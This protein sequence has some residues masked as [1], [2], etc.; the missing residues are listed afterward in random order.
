MAPQRTEDGR[1]HREDEGGD[2]KG[3]QAYPE[4][5]VRIVEA[6]IVRQ[7][8]DEYRNHGKIGHSVEEL[9]DV[10]KPEILGYGFQDLEFRKIFEDGVCGLIHGEMETV[11]KS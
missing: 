11:R 4:G 2:E 3:V 10:G 8:E 7:V 9:D 6:A 1:D 5:G